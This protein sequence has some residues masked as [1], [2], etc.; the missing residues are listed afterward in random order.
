MALTFECYLPVPWDLETCFRKIETMG[1][2]APIVK[3]YRVTVYFGSLLWPNINGNKHTLGWLIWALFIP[4][5]TYTLLKPGDNVHEFCPCFD[6]VGFLQ[7]CFWEWTWI[8]DLTGRQHFFV[9]LVYPGLKG[10]ENRSGPGLFFSFRIKRTIM[11]FSFWKLLLRGV[12]IWPWW[13]G[14]WNQSQLIVDP[15]GSDANQD[16]FCLPF[17]IC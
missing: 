8:P 6:P 10:T 11:I 14:L 3:L 15:I 7:G 16:Q 1:F 13:K 4:M 12:I 9:S 5:H 2:S 17:E